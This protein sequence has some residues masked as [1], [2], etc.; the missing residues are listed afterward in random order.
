[1]DIISKEHVIQNSEY[2]ETIFV[3]VPQ[4]TIMSHTADWTNGIRR[5]QIKDWSLKYERLTAMVVPRSSLYVDRVLILI[6]DLQVYRTIASD[7]EYTLFGVVVFRR[8][9]DEFVQKCRENKDA[10][11]LTF[12]LV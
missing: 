12:A 6:A 4:Y 7:E 5:T 8:V 2:L 1:M 10:F 11:P 9:H 3:A